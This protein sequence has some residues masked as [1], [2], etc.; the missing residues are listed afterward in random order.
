MRQYLGGGFD[1]GTFAPPPPIEA[2]QLAPRPVEG[3]AEGPVGGA[4]PE[5]AEETACPPVPEALPVESKPVVSVQERLR[6]LISDRTGYPVEMIELR[7]ALEPIMCR[8]AAL[9]SP[10]TAPLLPVGCVLARAQAGHAAARDLLA[11][12]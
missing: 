10:R 1:V 4:D 8:L 2:Q 12:R 9:R 7:I 3:M 5:I 11:N 6:A